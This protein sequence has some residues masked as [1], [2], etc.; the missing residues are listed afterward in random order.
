MSRRE[1]LRIVA[2]GMPFDDCPRCTA[3]PEQVNDGL[4]TCP[5][6]RNTKFITV[7]VHE[8]LMQTIE[9]FD[10]EKKLPVPEASSCETQNPECAGVEAAAV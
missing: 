9:Q 7:S 6:C 3:P 1:A 2:E 4:T 5:L 10:A 8:R